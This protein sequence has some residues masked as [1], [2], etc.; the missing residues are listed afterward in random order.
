MTTRVRRLR[1]TTNLRVRPVSRSAAGRKDRADSNDLLTGKVR[2]YK[3]EAEK[4]RKAR[5]RKPREPR[6][7]KPGA[8][9]KAGA[10]AALPV[11][12]EGTAKSFLNCDIMNRWKT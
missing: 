2:P 11:Q 6:V 12:R 3:P 7:G 10:L 8:G 1:A 9:L 5:D 4:I